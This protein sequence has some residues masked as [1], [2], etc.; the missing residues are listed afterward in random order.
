MTEAGLLVSIMDEC[1]RLG[2][3]VHH[4]KDSG[5]SEGQRKF[6]DL[7][8]AGR[9]GIMLVVLEGRNR[10]TAADPDLWRWTLHEADMLCSVKCERAGKYYG[11]WTPANWETGLIQERLMELAGG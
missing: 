11:V 9:A 2:L 5:N 7:V 4:C 1:G 10:K 3:L 8:I 6:P